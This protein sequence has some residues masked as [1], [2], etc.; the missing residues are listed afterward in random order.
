MSLE[1]MRA[2]GLDIDLAVAETRVATETESMMRSS[3]EDRQSRAEGL[4]LGPEE[5]RCW[6]E[7]EEEELGKQTER[8]HRTTEIQ[9]CGVI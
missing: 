7:E 6:G 2:S 5:L 3:L 8:A 1:L 9:Q 4:G